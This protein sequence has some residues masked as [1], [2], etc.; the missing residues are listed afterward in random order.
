MKIAARVEI[1]DLDSGRIIQDGKIFPPSDID[2]HGNY[3]VYRF[4]I[5]FMQHDNF[6]EKAYGE[7]NIKDALKETFKEMNKEE[8]D[9]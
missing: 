4:R 7:L 3:G 1:V 6:W 9:E 8:S 5:N 2:R